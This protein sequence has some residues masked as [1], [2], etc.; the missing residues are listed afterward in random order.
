MFGFQTPTHRI[1][2]SRCIMTPKVTRLTPAIERDQQLIA[3]NI[4][5]SGRTYQMGI[6]LVDGLQF[7]A[8][9]EFVAS[10]LG[11][12][13]FET[14]FVGKGLFV[15]RLYDFVEESRPRGYIV[16]EAERWRNTAAILCRI[17]KR[18]D[19]LGVNR[20]PK[21]IAVVRAIETQAQSWSMRVDYGRNAY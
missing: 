8:D 4:G 16:A 14:R 21:V 9:A 1:N 19:E 20:Q 17:F 18:I 10:R 5:H 15:R 12:R 7:P 3:V 2:V 6:L 11:R 13:L